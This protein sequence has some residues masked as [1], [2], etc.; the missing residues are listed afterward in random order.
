MAE[1]TISDFEISLI[2]GMLQRGMKPS[3]IQA[4]FTRPSRLVN[5]ARIQEIK[6]RDKGANIGAATGN[7]VDDFIDDFIRRNSDSSLYSPPNQDDGAST[8]SISDS[9]VVLNPDPP[10]NKLDNNDDIKDLYEEVRNKA[11]TFSL[12]GHNSLGG[13]VK[14]AISFSDA[15]PSDIEGASAI[16]IWMR[17]N[18]LRGYLKSH[19]VYQSNTDLYPLIAIDSTVA[20]AFED[21]VQSFNVLVSF[22]PALAALDDRRLDGD[23]R[24][25]QLD[26]LEAIK[27]AIDNSDEVAEP[28]AKDALEEQIGAGLRAPNTEEGRRQVALAYTSSRNFAVAIFTPIY[29]TVRLIFED[30]KLPNIIKK[31]RDG[32]ATA[33][34]SQFYQYITSH[35]PQIVDFININAKHISDYAQHLTDNQT[36]H[37]FITTLLSILA[38]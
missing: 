30:D 10:N 2:K 21:L 32:V 17:G 11:A 9:R 16:K 8:F 20:P 36:L 5:P 19:E 38:S 4:Y 14:D 23:K 22:V 15:F 25:E 1:S 37:D 28:S 7:E 12:L 31:F 24:S 34:G 18:T 13:L 6:N 26:A 27:P 35:Y 29:R 3:L 33:A